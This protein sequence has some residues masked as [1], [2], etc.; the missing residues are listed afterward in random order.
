MAL[1]KEPLR[2]LH[3]ISSLHV[4]GAQMHLYK[5]VTRFHP[6]KISSQ[7]VSLAGPGKI[8]RLIQAQGIT[9]FDLGMR[10]GSPTPGAWFALRGLLRRFRPYVLQTYLYHADLLGFLAGKWTGVPAIWWNLRQSRMDFSRYRRTTDLTVRLCARLSRRVDRILVNSYAGLQAHAR[11]GYDPGRMQV[12]PN[13]FE[14]DRFRPHPPSYQEVRR[15]LGLAPETQ[16]VG[17]L[18][19]FDP[20]KDHATFLEAASLLQKTL[21][22]THFLLAGKGLAPDNPALANLVAAHRL[23]PQRLSLLGERADAPRLLAALDVCV[24]ASAFGEGFPNVIGEA[25]A[26]GVPCVVTAV[27]DSALI[28]GETGLVV[29]PGQPKEMASALETALT[30][31]P[32]ERHRRGRAARARIQQQFDIN[33]VVGQLESMYL[34]LS[35]RPAARECLC[36]SLRF[37]KGY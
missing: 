31:L 16:L 13:G 6:E 15:E 10:P 7:V 29:Q 34:N 24:S 18:A 28:V 3:L 14:L 22:K 8:G 2:I 26:C 30:W 23:D 11:L 20:Q 17:M 35:A 27:G 37:E 19:R 5:T 36:P 25:M 33:Q 21:P 4:G 12:V 32:A 9:V 1:G